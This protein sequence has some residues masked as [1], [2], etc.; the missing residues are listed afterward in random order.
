MLLRGGYKV[1]RQRA[2][3]DFERSYLVGLI[4]YC[5]TLAAMSRVSGLS[6]QQLRMLLEKHDLDPGA[7]SARAAAGPR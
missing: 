3:D 2:V 5:T 6:T 4:A 7:P 1:A